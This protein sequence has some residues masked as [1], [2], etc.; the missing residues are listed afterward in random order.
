[1]ETEEANRSSTSART[2]SA[3]YAV[4]GDHLSHALTGST[5]VH[6]GDMQSTRTAGTLTGRKTRGAI[7]EKAFQN[8][9]SVRVAAVTGHPV[10]LHGHRVGKA[11][12]PGI[13]KANSRIREEEVED[14]D[15]QG[16]HSNSSRNSSGKAAQE[17]QRKA[18]CGTDGQQIR[19]RYRYQRQRR[20][21]QST[22]TLEKR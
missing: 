8:T 16:H 15:R 9:S 1:M 3:R 5:T 21:Q 13:S 4:R 22:V 12:R 7:M 17:A 11:M 14:M 18:I 10:N 2:R 6:V 19:C 20:W